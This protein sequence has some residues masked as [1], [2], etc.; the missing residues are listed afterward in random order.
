MGNCQSK[1]TST[2]N[3][4]QLHTHT[5]NQQHKRYCKTPFDAVLHLFRK[6]IRIIQIILHT[7]YSTNEA[8]AA[9]NFRSPQR[10]RAP[11]SEPSDK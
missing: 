7:L 4:Q 10:T 3:L 11:P 5:K 9:S 6:E 1:M 8:P 2:S